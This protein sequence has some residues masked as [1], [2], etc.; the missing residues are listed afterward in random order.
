MLPSQCMWMRRGGK[1]DMEGSGL[2]EMQVAVWVVI[3]VDWA[4]RNGVGAAVRDGVSH[5]ARFY[6]GLLAVCRDLVAGTDRSR[7]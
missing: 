3:A 5:G 2:L 6:D 4:W 7:S 1:G